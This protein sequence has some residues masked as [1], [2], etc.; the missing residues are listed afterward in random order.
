MRIGP[1]NFNPFEA[2]SRHQSTGA[3]VKYSPDGLSK[4][5]GIASQKTDEDLLR[6]EN[7]AAIG[8]HHREVVAQIKERNRSAAEGLFN[9]T[10]N[11][12]NQQKAQIVN[13]NVSKSSLEAQ[14][15]GFSP[16]PA[17]SQ[18]KQAAIINLHKAPVKRAS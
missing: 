14:N 11:K 9:R 16:N 12:Q 13:L 17:G 5:K 10:S 6:R 8:R 3:V 15:K 7:Q 4:V 2:V 1:L 18:Q